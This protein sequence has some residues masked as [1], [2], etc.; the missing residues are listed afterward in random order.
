MIGSFTRSRTPAPIMSAINPAFLESPGSG[1]AL[2]LSL[3]WFSGLGLERIFLARARG[4][5]KHVIHVNGTRG[6]SETTRLIAAALR[7][8]GIATFAKTT[9]TEARLIL[10][11]GSERPLRRLGPANVR[12]QR[13]FLLSAVRAGAEA[14]VAE[15][16]AV[17]PDAQYA[18]DAFLSPSVLVITNIR[19][20]HRL[21]LGDREST[22]RVFAAQIPKGGL[23]VLGDASLEPAFRVAAA[24]AGAKLAVA[25]PCEVRTGDTDAI[26]LAGDEEAFPENVAMALTVAKACGIPGEV[27]IA[28][29]RNCPPDPGRYSI[30]RIPCNGEGGYFTFLDALA[31]NDPEST[32]ILIARAMHALPG[33]YTEH[34]LLFSAR[35]DRPDRSIAF[36]EH[37]SSLEPGAGGVAWNRLIVH[38]RLPH[39]AESLFKTRF[40]SSTAKASPAFSRMKSDDLAPILQNLRPGS[41]ICATGNWQKLGPALSFLP[42][43]TGTPGDAP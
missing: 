9:G 20:D 5:L 17:S 34:V 15:C 10:P 12:E 40:N 16:M 23:V 21:E 39:R 1:I 11:D 25:D 42:G 19:D 32:D 22:M 29:M 24:S 36:A 26:P 38:G 28:G 31:A 14:A 27:A 7:A 2:I 41:L 6:K 13:R 8:G 37:W 3:L 30:R 43:L 18:S 35:E 4:R 33:P